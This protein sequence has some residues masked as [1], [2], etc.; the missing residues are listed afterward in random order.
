MLKV[1]TFTILNNFHHRLVIQYFPKAAL[2]RLG[3]IPSA[4][5]FLLYLI[6]I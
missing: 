5:P 1:L 2:S 6:F 3:F 4:L